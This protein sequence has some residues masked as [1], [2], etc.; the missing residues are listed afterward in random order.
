MK[1]CHDREYIK[2]VVSAI[3]VPE[4]QPKKATI[5]VDDK[6]T[7]EEKVEDDDEAV[8]ELAKYLSGLTV[9]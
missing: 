1:Y 5:K 6:D 7:T 3:H 8:A 9:V 2:K 4:Y